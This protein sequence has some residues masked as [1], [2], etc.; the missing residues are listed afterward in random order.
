MTHEEP[1]FLPAVC[2]DDLLALYAI[3]LKADGIQLPRWRCAGLVVRLT[4]SIDHRRSLR[5]PKPSCLGR[6]QRPRPYQLTRPQSDRQS[7]D[8]RR[9]RV[10][11]QD[12]VVRGCVAGVRNRQ[13]ARRRCQRITVVHIE[14]EPSIEISPCIEIPRRA[15]QNAVPQRPD[16]KHQRDRLEQANGMPRFRLVVFGGMATNSV[17][18]FADNIQRSTP[19]A[20]AAVQAM[21]TQV[22]R[23]RPAPMA[24][25]LATSGNGYG[26]VGQRAGQNGGQAGR[27][28]TWNVT[29]NV[30]GGNGDAQTIGRS[31]EQ[32]ML[33]AA[34]ARGLR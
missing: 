33:R 15:V 25:A 11:G 32:G 6:R 34:R 12:H 16:P 17:M 9:A 14:I 31:V 4:L 29:I 27:G 1:R 8:W 13:R 19:A 10:E 7:S 18:S 21:M 20:V 22:S 28:D 5:V 2:L 3:Q 26:A 30:N 23:V 24:L